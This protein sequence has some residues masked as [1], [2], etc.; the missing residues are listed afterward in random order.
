MSTLTWVRVTEED[1]LI[2]EAEQALNIQYDRQVEEFYIN[3]KKRAEAVSQVY[4][5]KY[6]EK[7]FGDDS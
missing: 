6:L 1:I 5:D 4:E 3:A 7:L 2:E